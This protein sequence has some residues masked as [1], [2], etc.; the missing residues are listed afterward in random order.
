MRFKFYL[1]VLM[2]CVDT[3]SQ[4]VMQTFEPPFD[5]LS[6]VLMKNDFF[7]L[8]VRNMLKLSLLVL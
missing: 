7:E 5:A 3:V 1:I 4:A 2:F 6:T 8:Q